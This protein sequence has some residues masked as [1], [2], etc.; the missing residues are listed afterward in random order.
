MKIIFL[1]FD[2]VMDTVEYVTSRNLWECQY[3]IDMELYSTLIVC[4]I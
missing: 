3:V 2:G 1:D 4:S